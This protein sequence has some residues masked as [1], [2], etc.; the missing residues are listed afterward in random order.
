MLRRTMNLFPW[1]AIALFLSA[2]AARAEGVR[3][4]L[5]R[6]NQRG[7]KAQ[8]ENDQDREFQRQINSLQSRECQLGLSASTTPS[9]PETQREIQKLHSQI[10]SARS[11]MKT[12]WTRLEKVQKDLRMYRTNA[13]LTDLNSQTPSQIATFLNDFGA[14]TLIPEE[15]ALKERLITLQ[16]SIT[17][18]SCQLTQFLRDTRLYNRPN[19]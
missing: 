9:D 4:M 14:E 13:L 17:D 16:E 5:D 2:S 11:E 12:V 15:Q 19:Q 1:L 8:Q 18:W 7:Q 3:Q 10:Q 6:L